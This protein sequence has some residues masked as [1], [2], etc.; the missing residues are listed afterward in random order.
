VQNIFTMQFFSLN[1][2]SFLYAFRICLGCIIVWLTLNYFH[3]SKKIW[4]LI[5]VILISDPDFDNVRNSTVSRVINTLTGCILGIFFIYFTGVNFWS[6]MLAIT[7]AVIIST[8][9]KKYPSSWKLAP[10]TVA[11]IMASAI[12]ED[13][14]L[15]GAM[16]IAISRTAEVLYGSLIAFLL[17]FVLLYIEKKSKVKIV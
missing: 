7:V 3:D 4:A 10:V 2:N 5:S 1:N 12:S 16:Q 8:S 13:S 11:I 17:A 15:K 9:F 14:Q 6:L